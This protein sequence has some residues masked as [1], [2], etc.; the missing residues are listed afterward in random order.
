MKKELERRYDAVRYQQWFQFFDGNGRGLCVPD[1]FVDLGDCLL[2]VEVKLTG[3]AHAKLQMVDLY[4]PILHHV[5]GKPVRSLLVCK[6]LHHSAPGPFFHDVRDFVASRQP[7]GC[8]HW[9]GD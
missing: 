9:I 8:W 6:W 5:Y 4:A 2:L 1:A 3:G 7:Y